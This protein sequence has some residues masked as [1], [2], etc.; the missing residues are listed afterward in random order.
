MSRLVGEVQKFGIES[1]LPNLLCESN[2]AVSNVEH[3]IHVLFSA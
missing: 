3:R 2:A 1:L